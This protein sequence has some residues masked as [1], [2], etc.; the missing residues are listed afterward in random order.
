MIK[1]QFYNRRLELY[2]NSHLKDFDSEIEWYVNPAPNQWK[3]ELRG[4]ITVLT[5]DDNGVVHKQLA[6]T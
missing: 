1:D 4:V 5:C 3:F 2:Y 6:G